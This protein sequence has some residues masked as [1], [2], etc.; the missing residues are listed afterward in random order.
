MPL[1]AVMPHV[2]LSPKRL[3]G[4]RQNE[5]AKTLENEKQRPTKT[6]LYTINTVTHDLTT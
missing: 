6:I 5:K 3:Q 4:D 1:V 2:T